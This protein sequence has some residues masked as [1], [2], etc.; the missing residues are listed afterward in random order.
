MSNNVPEFVITRVF[1]APRQR[2]WDAW[3]KPKMYARWSGPKGVVTTVLQFDMRPGGIVHSRMEGPDGSGMYGKA[4]YRE[5]VPPSRLVWVN[6]FSDEHANVI[7][8]PFDQPWPREMLTTV[9]FE[10]EGADT[11]ITLTW[12]PL[13]A[14]PEEIR[15]FADNMMSMQGGWTGSFDQLDAFLAEPA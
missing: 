15:T 12:V 13:G 6:S 9:A 10:D 4:V 1:K 3:T 7:A 2:V 5:V 11:R 14:T 8:P